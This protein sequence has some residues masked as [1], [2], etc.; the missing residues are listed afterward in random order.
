MINM[1]KHDLA[2][3][4]LGGRRSYD[5]KITGPEKLLQRF[6]V[7]LLTP[8]GSDIYRPRRGTMFMTAWNRGITTEAYLTQIFLLSERQARGNLQ[9]EETD[10][11]PA[12]EQYV[13]TTIS[14]LEIAQDMVRLHLTTKSRAGT[15]S[16]I[17]P[18][19]VA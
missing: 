1:P 3:W 15:A 8:R 18:L 4:P 2:I 14:R 13:N 9:G 10:D 12:N 16:V 19:S 11:T 7:E 6:L 5:K 17:L